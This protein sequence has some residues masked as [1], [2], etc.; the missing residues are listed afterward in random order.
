MGGGWLRGVAE[1]KDVWQIKDLA[2]IPMEARV[3]ED[4]SGLTEGVALTT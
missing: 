4:A 3:G 2:E 1:D